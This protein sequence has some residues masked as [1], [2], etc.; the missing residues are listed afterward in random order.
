MSMWSEASG[1]GRV[2]VMCSEWSPGPNC[3]NHM[4]NLITFGEK[5]IALH[6]LKSKND[7]ILKKFHYVEMEIL[8]YVQNMTHECTLY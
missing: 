3:I 1:K 6:K 2:S 8:P 7:H 5:K 4:A